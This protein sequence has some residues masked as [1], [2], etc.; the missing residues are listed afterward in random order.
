MAARKVV[1]EGSSNVT[2]PQLREM[3]KQV[4]QR[5]LDGYHFQAFLEHRNPFEIIYPMK[6][7]EVDVDYDRSLQEMISDGDFRWKEQDI[8][9]TVFHLPGRGK[10]KER[11]F[12]CQCD[13]PI[14]T[15]DAIRALARF[16]REPANIYQMLALMLAHPETCIEYPTVALASKTWRGSQVTSAG[17][18]VPHAFH[19]VAGRHLL[20]RRADTTMWKRTHQFLAVERPLEVPS[21]S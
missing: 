10:R 21:V 19:T 16:G 9:D 15:D 17:F 2:A 20:L 13:R 11:L 14:S 5:K 3:F 18:Y 4:E 7:F 12:V 1:I 6:A 8:T